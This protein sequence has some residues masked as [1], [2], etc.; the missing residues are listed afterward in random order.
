MALCGAQ[1]SQKFTSILLLLLAF[2]FQA[3]AQQA[4]S[5][6]RK[7][8][9][10]VSAGISKEQLALEDQLNAIISEGDQALKSGDAAAAIKQYESARDLVQI[11]PL[12]AEQ[13]DRTMKKLGTGYFQGKR[14][15]EAIQICSDRVDTKRKDCESESTAVS[16]CAE[17]ESDLCTA[18]MYDNDFN[19]ALVCF[20]DVEAKYVNAQK[21]SDIHEFTMIETMHEA[22]AKISISLMLYQLGRTPEAIVSTETAIKELSS[23]QNDQNIQQ[24]IRDEAANSLQ[25]TQTHLARLKAVQ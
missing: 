16:N 1:M 18:R 22:E 25:A 13:K 17:A 6:Q 7:D 11:K 5:V 4:P 20:R 23:V 12:L 9:I 14:M 24:G 10:V 3:H 21:F 19:D 2:T 15:K 8:S